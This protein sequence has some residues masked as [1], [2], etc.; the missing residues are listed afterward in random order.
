MIKSAQNIKNDKGID[1]KNRCPYS[2]AYYVKPLAFQTF[3]APVS[4][5]RS[6][7][8]AGSGAEK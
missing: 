1:R 3:S 4:I 5:F 6:N 7:S 8:A 2:S